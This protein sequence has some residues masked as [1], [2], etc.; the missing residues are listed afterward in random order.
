MGM[1]VPGIDELRQRRHDLGLTQKQVAEL[2]G[3]SQ[4]LVARIEK[5]TVDPRMSTFRRIV[6]ALNKIEAQKAP[7]AR[8]LMSTKVVGAGPND[9]IKKIIKMM[10]QH[11]YSQLPVVERGRNLGSITERRIL[12]EIERTENPQDLSNKRVRDLMGPAL[13]TVEPDADMGTV[14]H[15]LEAYPALL[16]TEKGEIVGVITKADAMRLIP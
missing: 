6:N 1:T 12:Q 15:M 5:G 9:P 13:P 3:I 16:V 14:N 4:P 7:V 2:A 10:T 8:D 11:G